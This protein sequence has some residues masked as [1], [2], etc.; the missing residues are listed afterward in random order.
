[1]LCLNIQKAL[2]T[3]N[4]AIFFGD[5][6][7]PRLTQLLG[8]DLRTKEKTCSTIDYSSFDKTMQTEIIEM[9]FEIL[10]SLIDFSHMS[11][12]HMHKVTNG[13]EPK[14]IPMNPLDQ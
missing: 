10:E 3:A 8:F 9:A 4:G 6:S 7:M 12:E 1:M 13:K 11:N 14:Y 5:N 2:K